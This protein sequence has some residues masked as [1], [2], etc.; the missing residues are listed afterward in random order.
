[1]NIY[2]V[3]EIPT[4]LYIKM[5]Q[6]ILWPETLDP[7]KTQKIIDAVRAFGWEKQDKDRVAKLYILSQRAETQEERD[8]AYKEWEREKKNLDKMYPPIEDP[9]LKGRR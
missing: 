9:L 7:N 8:K 5:V 2:G 1:M 4:Q 6:Y 3:V